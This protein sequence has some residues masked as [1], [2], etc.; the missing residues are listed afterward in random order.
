MDIS[1]EGLLGLGNNQKGL[2]PVVGSSDWFTGSQVPAQT[3]KAVQSG[4]A[5]GL[6]V[7]IGTG[8][9]LLGGL[10]TLG[11]LWTAWNASDL[12]KKQFNFQKDLSTANYANQASAYNTHLEDRAYARYAQENKSPGE[13]AA[14]IGAHQ[15]MPYLPSH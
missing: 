3:D 15:V 11:N 1:L 6:G 12:A 14:Y 10:G 9:L 8:Q 5:T 7:N 4:P 2:S 13:A